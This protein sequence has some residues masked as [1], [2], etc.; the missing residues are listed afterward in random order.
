MRVDDTAEVAGR[1][2]YQLV[3]EPRD[4]GSLVGSVRLAVDAATSVPLRVQV[5]GVQDAQEPALEV[6]FTEVSFDRPEA[7]VFDFAAP[8]DADVEGRRGARGS[9]RR[10][11]AARRRPDPSGDGPAGGHRLGLG[12]RRRAARPRRRRRL[13]ESGSGGLLDSL[14]T[15]VPEGRLLHDPLL[16]ALI[17]DDGRLL[18]GAVPGEGC[19]RAPAGDRAVL[20][21]AADGRHRRA[22]LAVATR[23]LTK[24]FRSGQVAVDGIDLQVPPGAVY[25]FLGPNGSGKTTTIRMLLGLVA[26][27]SGEAHV[28][29]RPMP[30]GARAGAAPGGGARRGAGLPPVPVRRGQPR[31][32]GRRRRHRRPAH[33]R[34]A[35]AGARS[36]GS[37][38]R[39]RGPSATGS[40]PSA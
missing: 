3:L 13:Q 1:D 25:G 22:G 6:G 36:T 34:R 18:V 32:G 35:R 24:R 28:L 19:A 39:P 20:R 29:G 26:P 17:T 33:P 7:S 21:R 8:P 30:A 2:A 11:R 37:A 40:T 10:R 38:W 14:T 15:R 4:P 9:A 27:T 5:W 31:P 23:G 12:P 16:S